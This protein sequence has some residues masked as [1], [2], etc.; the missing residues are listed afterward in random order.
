MVRPLIG[1][2]GRRW[3]VSFL[4]ANVV[5]AMKDLT[6]DLHFSDYPRSVALAGGLPVEL[7]RDADVQDIVSRLDGLVLSGGADVNPTLYDHEADS[8]L[9]SVEDERDEWELGLYREARKRG[10]PVLAICRGFQLVNVASGGTLVQHVELDEGSGHPQWEVDGRQASHA[11]T[12]T[13]GTVTS[14]YLS[15]QIQVNSLHHQTVAELGEGLVASAYAPDGVIEGFES[16]D[17]LVLGVQW[18]PELL[19]APDPTFKWLVEA[20]SASLT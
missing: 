7:A 15:P 3:P 2:S 16:T 20:S 17:G 1:I 14:K 4:G 8:N 6:F 11:A 9:G 13:A 18:H 12:V 10:I 19:V 5:A